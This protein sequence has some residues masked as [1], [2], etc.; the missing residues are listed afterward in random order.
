MKILFAIPHYYQDRGTH[1]VRHGSVSGRSTERL[2]SFS[3][4]LSAIRQLFGRPQCLIDVADRTTK[5]VNQLT[6]ELVDVI[7]HTTGTDHLV[8]QLRLGSDYFQHRAT[9]AQPELLG[10]ECHATLRE[11]LGEYDYY[12]YLEDD[13]VIRDPLFFEK[14][15][16][17]T[18]TFRRGCVLAP[19]RFEVTVNAIVHKAYVDG[20]LNPHVTCLFQ[21]VTE[22]PSLEVELFARTIRFIRPTNPHCGGFFLTAEQMAHLA[23]SPHFLDR[24]TRFIG[25]LESAATL[26]VMRTFRV[27][28]PAPEN[29]CFLEVE[30]QG[31]AFLNRI[32]RPHQDELTA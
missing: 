15:R 7:V 26:G 9:A 1:S 25:P 16:W 12:C 18:H 27:Y 29:A 8:D 17:F 32:R 11:H 20:P 21:D 10:F 5:P 24:D 4:C 22:Q 14:I 28:K 13:L 3:Q 30:H 31:A 2:A 6:A 23:E 19:N